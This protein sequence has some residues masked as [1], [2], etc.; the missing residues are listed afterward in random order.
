MGEDFWKISWA[1][2]MNGR[3]R[4]E[5]RMTLF[6]IKGVIVNDLLK[7]NEPDWEIFQVIFFMYLASNL[8]LND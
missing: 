2:M 5:M 1:R 6:I 7:F 8:R 3:K 4:I